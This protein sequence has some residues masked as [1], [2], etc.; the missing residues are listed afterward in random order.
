MNDYLDRCL[1]IIETSTD[2]LPEA[3]L[4]TRDDG[5]WS[6]LAIV[7]H[8]QLTYSGTAKGFDRCLE[9]GAPSA[10]RFSLAEK[11]Q[12]FAVLRIGYFPQ[13]LQAPKFIVPKGGVDLATA[14]G[15][16]RHSLEWLDGS[17]LRARERFGSGAILDHP[18]LGAFTVDEWLRFHWRHTE[19]HAKQIRDRSFR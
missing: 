2:R 10:K 1:A 9:A 18:F 4:T 15:R 16:T 11:F 7:E 6:V 19:H 12:K 13:G 5:R 3:A 17:A 14:I 8:L